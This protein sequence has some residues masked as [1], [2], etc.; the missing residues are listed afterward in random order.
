LRDDDSARSR[1]WTGYLVGSLE[2]IRHEVAE[3]VLR[4]LESLHVKTQADRL[5]GLAKAR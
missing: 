1:P 5:Q 2:V 4:G 3:D